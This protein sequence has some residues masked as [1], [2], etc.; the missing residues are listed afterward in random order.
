MAAPVTKFAQDASDRMADLIAKN[1]APWQKPWAPGR[2]FRPYNPTTDKSYRGFNTIWLQAQG[3]SDSRWMTYNQA[4]A[5]GGQVRKGEKSTAIQFWQWS[6][7]EKAVDSQ[8]NPILGPDGKQRMVEVQLDRPRVRHAAVFNAEQIDGLPPEPERPLAPEWER[9]ARAEKILAASPAAVR[10]VEGD[11]AYYSP[12]ADAITLPLREQFPNPGNFYAT[13]LHE[14]GHSTGHVSRL[15]RDLTGPFGSEL[16]AREELVAEFTSLFVGDELGIGHDPSRHASYVESWLRVIKEDPNALLRAAA[17]AEKASALVLGLERE[18]SLEKTSEIERQAWAA[19]IEQP[20]SGQAPAERQKAMEERVHALAAT[21]PAIPDGTTRAYHIEPTIDRP[22]R[23]GAMSGAGSLAGTGAWFT[24]DVTILAQVASSH[25]GD[26]PEL[27]YVDRPR[28]VHALHV[29]GD[30][31]EFF[32]PASL[33]EKRVPIGIVS[34]VDQD[35][36]QLMG[37]ASGLG[38][39]EPDLSRVQDL[40]A[41]IVEQVAQVIDHGPELADIPLAGV[42]LDG[43]RSFAEQTSGH[44]TVASELMARVAPRSLSG[45]RPSWL[46]P[47][48]ALLKAIQRVERSVNEREQAERADHFKAPQHEAGKAGQGDTMQADDNKEVAKEKIAISVPFREKDEAKRLGAKWDKTDKT[49]F[50][51]EGTAIAP[52]AKWT[53]GRDAAEVEKSAPEIDPAAIAAERLNISVPF[54]EKGAARELGAKWDKTDK[55][56][57]IPEGAAIAPFAKWI[58]E[59]A[60][61]PA[62]DPHVEFGD[63]IRSMGLQ[64]KGLPE[65]YDSGK[66]KQP[67]IRI[68]VDGDAPGEKSGAYVGYLDGKRPGGFIQNYKTGKEMTWWSSAPVPKLSPEEQRAQEAQRALLQQARDAEDLAKHQAVAK[69]V[70][71]LVDRSPA[72]QASNPYLERK[73]VDGTSIKQMVEAIRFPLDAPFEKQANFGGKDHLLVPAHDLDGRV[74]TAQAIG[75]NGF[76]AYPKGSRLAGSHHLL[77]GEGLEAPGATVLL[78]EGYATAKTLAMET[79]LPTL[80]TFSANNLVTVAEQL[81][82]RY[83]DHLLVLA[84]DNDHRKELQRD[85]QGRPKPNVGKE[86]AEKAAELTKGYTLLPSFDS[87]SKGSDWNDLF[88]E[89]PKEFKRQVGEGL[90]A[91]QLEARARSLGLATNVPDREKERTLV[92]ERENTKERAAPAR[93]VEMAR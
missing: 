38:L 87:Q 55:T 39:T 70:A 18:L 1:Q 31:K 7:M 57:F 28:D 84:G 45:G 77:N 56:W 29:S 11:S 37:L 40:H 13:A 80:A 79:G 88:A 8:G 86:K 19:H 74:W 23:V 50:I 82:E 5:I 2:R 26:R 16:Y 65:M 3:R 17:Q 51:P 58:E 44:L 54:E 85:E 24:T 14:I 63:A 25:R 59:Q 47:P 62:Q 93:G 67:M 32:L 9:H 83:P 27:S 20:R 68:P 61:S 90:A 34:T 52:F 15:D 75:P 22:D 69:D 81:R 48:E 89:N 36:E 42:P 35:R 46:L 91:I 10:F 33:V 53:E 73:G 49:W 66:V 92:K 60:R 41:E 64:L 76:K 78:A 43:L 21:L 71:Q 4:A 72:A 30:G 6:T 12:G